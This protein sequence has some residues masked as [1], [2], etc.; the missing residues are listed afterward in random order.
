MATRQEIHE[1]VVATLSESFGLRADV[2][3]PS[4]RLVTDLDLDSI[5]AIDLAVHLEMR[6]GFAPKG[7][8]LRSLVTLDDVVE[9]L[10]RHQPVKVGIADDSLAPP[11]A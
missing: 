11:H 1:Q 6:L 2:L 7:G 4:A 10:H 8:E 5:D 9:F 3:V